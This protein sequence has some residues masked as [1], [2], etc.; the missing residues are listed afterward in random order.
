MRDK[1]YNSDKGGDS[2]QE[3]VRVNASPP[4]GSKYNQSRENRQ[5]I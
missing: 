3:G 4:V 5:I 1:Y 2:I